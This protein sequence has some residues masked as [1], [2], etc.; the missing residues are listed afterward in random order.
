MEP[1]PIQNGK[2]LLQLDKILKEYANCTPG[3]IDTPYI[4]IK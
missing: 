4:E 1:S 2:E 3:A